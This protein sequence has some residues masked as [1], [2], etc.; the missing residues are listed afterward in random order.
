MKESLLKIF[1][2]EI[3]YY[4]VIPIVIVLLGWVKNERD[5]KEKNKE[6]GY[7][8]LKC[9]KIPTFPD[10]ILKTY[11]MMAINLLI[12]LVARKMFCY[13]KGMIFSYIIC[14]IWYLGINA[15]ITFKNCK[16][17]N[18]K[19]EFWQDGK[20]KK[21]LAITLYLI[22]AIS[23]LTDFS[24]KYSW[25][26][27]VIFIILLIVWI[28]CLLNYCDVAFILDNRYADIYVKGSER[29]Q[30][31]EAGSIRKHGEWIIVNRYVNGYDE[32]IRIKES[33]IVRIDYYGEPMIMVEKRNLFSKRRS[34]E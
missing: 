26:V 22:F 4:V 18:G 16:S 24:G 7:W 31:A 17:Q 25:I 28:I 6:L 21:K 33:D 1:D 29:A 20:L 34:S 13:W 5:L 11:K 19:I 2:S 27:E 9:R 10:I 12:T 32:E 30:F 8:M 3:M 14:G 23:T 15:I